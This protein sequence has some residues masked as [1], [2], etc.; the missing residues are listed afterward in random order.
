MYD[1]LIAGIGLLKA[2]PESEVKL[3]PLREARVADIN[4]SDLRRD[5]TLLHLEHTE[6]V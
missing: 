1:R 4:P 2:T 5:H 6:Q 3:D